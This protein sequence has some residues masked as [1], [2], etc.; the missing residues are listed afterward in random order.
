MLFS[1]QYLFQKQRQCKYLKFP[2]WCFDLIQS[3][4]LSFILAVYVPRGPKSGSGQ[5]W[6]RSSLLGLYI[7][8]TCMWVNPP[9]GGRG[10]LSMQNKQFPSSGRCPCSTDGPTPMCIAAALIGS[11]K[12]RTWHCGAG[13]CFVVLEKVKMGEGQI[14]SKYVISNSSLSIIF[15]NVF[16]FFCWHVSSEHVCL[17]KSTDPTTLQSN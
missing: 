12:K 3:Q 10:V 11:K 1:S 5:Q 7:R 4:I 8:A 17:S 15:S 13:G 16:G 9:Q 6:G 14:L 2:I